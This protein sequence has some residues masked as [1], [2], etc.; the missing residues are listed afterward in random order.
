MRPGRRQIY[1]CALLGKEQWDGHG[2]LPEINEIH[3]FDWDGNLCY[4]L[5]ADRSFFV[6]SARP[7]SA[8]VSIHA[9]G[10]Q[11]TYIIWI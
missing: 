1:L 6:A 2:S 8:T 11:M 7:W 10:I 5:T 9:I 4:K 3:V